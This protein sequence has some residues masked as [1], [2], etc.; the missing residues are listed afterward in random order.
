[1]YAQSQPDESVLGLVRKLAAA[2]THRLATLNNE[3]RELNRYRIDTFGL[4]TMFQAFFSS[5]YLGVGKPNARIFA[6]ALDVMQ[7][8]PAESLFV[9]D[10][11]TN[12]AAARA[13][14]MRAIHMTDPGRLPQALREAGVDLPSPTV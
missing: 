9:D 13:L 10:R 7:A 4:D 8:D 5:C 6:I 14:G 11:E 3:S 2:R 12:V 1:M